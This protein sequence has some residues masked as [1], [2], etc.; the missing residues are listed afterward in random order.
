MRKKER[1]RE[2]LGIVRSRLRKIMRDLTLTNMESGTHVTAT[3]SY[4]LELAA[5]ARGDTRSSRGNTTCRSRAEKRDTV[6]EHPTAKGCQTLCHLNGVSLK[7][8]SNCTPD[9]NTMDR[10]FSGAQLII[11]YRRPS[12]CKL[13]FH[14]ANQLLQSG[15]KVV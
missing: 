12:P 7:S 1:R 10:I 6:T 13:R 3:L 14:R 15:H 8:L 9:H 2:S 4:H 11:E 5:T